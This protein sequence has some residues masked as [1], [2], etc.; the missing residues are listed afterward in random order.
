LLSHMGL[1]GMVPTTIHTGKRKR[2]KPR[3][4]NQSPRRFSPRLSSALH[5]QLQTTRCTNSFPKP[6]LAPCRLTGKRQ[7]VLCVVRGAGGRMRRVVRRGWPGH[8]LFLSV[9]ADAFR[10]IICFSYERDRSGSTR[11]I[12]SRLIE[13]RR[14]FCRPA[15]LKTEAHL[16]CNSNAG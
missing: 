13:S 4:R 2:D 6:L 1:I 14:V 9:M 12:K 7:R 3:A 15:L 16:H 10:P 5:K 8:F 11:E